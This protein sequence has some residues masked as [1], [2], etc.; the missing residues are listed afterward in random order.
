VT[1]GSAPF[2]GPPLEGAKAGAVELACSCSLLE[3]AHAAHG[4]PRFVTPSSYLRYLAALA[5][6]TR[7][8]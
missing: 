4:C 3:Y 6:Y 8:G 2:I 1:R 5:A 7:T